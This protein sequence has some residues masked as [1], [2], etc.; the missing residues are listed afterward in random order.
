[1]FKKTHCLPH[2]VKHERT[3]AAGGGVVYNRA[4][5]KKNNMDDGGKRLNVP[6]LHYKPLKCG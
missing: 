1:M 6:T 3:G 2:M 4:Q 5:E